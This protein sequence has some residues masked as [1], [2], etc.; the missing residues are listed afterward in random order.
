MHF[1]GAEKIR[2]KV[3]FINRRR[4]DFRRGKRLGKDDHMV[5]CRKP[6]SIRSIGKPT[7]LF[8]TS[9][10]LEKRESELKL[11][12]F[13]QRINVVTTLLDPV[14]YPNKDLATLYRARWQQELDFRSIKVASQM[15]VLRCKIPELVRKQEI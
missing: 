8:P 1:L 15:D 13:G 3:G 14:A 9:C 12:V 10:L 11:L 7:I 6:N 2:S 5:I 4:A